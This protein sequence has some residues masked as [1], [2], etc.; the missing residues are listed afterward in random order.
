MT[1]D[2]EVFVGCAG[3][4]ASGMGDQTIG[5]ARQVIRGKLIHK[6]QV[7]IVDWMGAAGLLDGLSAAVSSDFDAAFVDRGE[8]I[9]VA[10]GCFEEEAGETLALLEPR[11]A[12]GQPILVLAQHS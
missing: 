2:H 12:G 4:V 6:A 1:V 11:G 7:I 5:Q 8:A 3:V 9:E 10:L